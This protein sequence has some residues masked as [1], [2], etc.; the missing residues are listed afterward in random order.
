MKYEV[1][2]H[3]GKNVALDLDLDPDPFTDPKPWF[4]PSHANKKKKTNIYDLKN[5]LSSKV[6]SRSSFLYYRIKI[7]DL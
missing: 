2:V 6:V 7:P 5:S 4:Q 3:T 1:T